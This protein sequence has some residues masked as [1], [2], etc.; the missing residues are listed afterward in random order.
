MTIR[1]IN[2]GRFDQYV[3]EIAR[4]YQADG[5]SVTVKPDPSVLPDAL[6]NIQFD[7]L[8]SRASETL[9]IEIKDNR[10]VRRVDYWDQTKK[11]VETVPNWHYVVIIPGEG[12]AWLDDPTVSSEAVNELVNEAEALVRSHHN[13]A[14]LLTSWIA[15]ELALR[16]SVERHGVSAR[17]PSILS[18]L[19]ALYDE[20]D[21]DP[22]EYSQL[23]AA[24]NLRNKVAHGQ[25]IDP[26]SVDDIY[27]VVSKT[28]ELLAA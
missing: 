22:D 6:R 7:L 26:V 13:N 2:L 9:G 3:E 20:G 25:Q 5:Y 27:T 17:V 24:L 8:A 15:L 10:R 16:T 23:R 11:L 12:E 1:A 14:A 4:Q 18:L 21:I 28:K 19:S